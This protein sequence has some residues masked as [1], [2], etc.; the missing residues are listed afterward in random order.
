[1]AAPNIQFYEYDD[2][3]MLSELNPIEFGDVPR[4]STG[5]PTD[6]LKQGVNLWND[7][8]GIAGSDEAINIRISVLPDD[9]DLDSEVFVGTEGNG[10][11]PFLE[12]RSK[13]AV[14][15]SDD[16]QTDWTPI[17]NDEFLE[18]GDMPRN[19]MRRIELRLNIPQ[20][21]TSFVSKDYRLQVNYETE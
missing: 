9:E 21:A 10:F 18:I 11:Q 8:D 5:I 12:A 16:A 17:S 20:D 13:G 3:D 4:G 7:R 14:N 2:V 6:S 1:M 19:S 15:V